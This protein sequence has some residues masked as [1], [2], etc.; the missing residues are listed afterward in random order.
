M[1]PYTRTMAKNAINKIKLLST[2]TFSSS[3]NEIIFLDNMT[4]GINN[5][6]KAAKA[7]IPKAILP[8]NKQRKSKLTR[9]K[10]K[11]MDVLSYF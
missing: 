4:K 11:Q 3:Q 8:K 5:M 9:R 7:M 1:A 2:L 10:L 6:I